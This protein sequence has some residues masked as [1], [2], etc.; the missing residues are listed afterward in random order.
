MS[1]P[2]QRIAIR[3]AV[4]TIDPH[5]GSPHDML[6]MPI[7]SICLSVCLSQLHCTFGVQRVGPQC[8]RQR[9][10]S[11]LTMPTETVLRSSTTM[12][13]QFQNTQTQQAS[14]SLSHRRHRIAI[15][16]AVPTIV[17]HSGSPHDMLTMPI[18]SVCLSVCLSVTTTLYVW[19][20][21]I[22]ISEPTRPY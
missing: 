16:I 22:H 12:N 4:S 6:T 5:S 19:L 3:M 18:P 1:H 8:Q 9:A 20:S 13:R 11:Q 14:P 21:L 10:I 2:R 15:R 7:P 17:P